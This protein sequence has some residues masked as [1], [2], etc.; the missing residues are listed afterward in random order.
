MMRGLDRVGVMLALMIAAFSFVRWGAQFFMSEMPCVRLK[1]K[2]DLADEFCAGVARKYADSQCDP[3]EE[4]ARQDCKKIFFVNYTEVCLQAIDI[5][6]IRE[7]F[8]HA[9]K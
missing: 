5:D 2:A 3:L 9:C 7:D 8:E 4:D 6:H 1:A